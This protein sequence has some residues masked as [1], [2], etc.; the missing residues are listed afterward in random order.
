MPTPMSDAEKEVRSELERRFHHVQEDR[1]LI[2]TPIFG[3]HGKL[4]AV[5]LTLNGSP[6]RG[7]IYCKLDHSVFS[8][9]ERIKI[10]RIVFIGDDGSKSL[11]RFE[12]QGSKENPAAIILAVEDFLNGQKIARMDE[13]TRSEANS[14]QE[15]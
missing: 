4:T 3:D 11:G 1:L 9:D 7:T 13:R 12:T 8:D 5:V 15:A 14:S 2:K 6:P 10:Q